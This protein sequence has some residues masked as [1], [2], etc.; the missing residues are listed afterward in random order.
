MPQYYRVTKKELLALIECKETCLAMGGELQ[1]EAN[2]ADKAAKAIFKRNNI[3]L[4]QDYS[5]SY[6]KIKT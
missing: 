2:I 6:K 4:T 1:A 5:E 3:S